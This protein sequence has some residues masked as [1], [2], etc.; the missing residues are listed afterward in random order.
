[1]TRIES[2]L[3]YLHTVE[4]GT[5]EECSH[6]RQESSIRHLWNWVEVT[7]WSEPR[8]EDNLFFIIEARRAQTEQT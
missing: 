2:L 1:M 6:A 4:N 8:I 5:S 7:G 3:L